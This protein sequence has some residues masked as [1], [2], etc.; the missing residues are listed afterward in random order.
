MNK[1]LNN[2]FIQ[3]GII[4]TLSTVI[5]NVFNYIFH[6]LAA[7]TLGPADYGEIVALFSYMA[8]LSIPFST[9][10][11]LIIRRLGYA[12]IQRDKVAKAIDL[13]FSLRIRH[14]WLI[15]LFFFSIMFVIPRI[16]GLQ[17]STGVVLLFSVYFGLINSFYIAILTGLHFFKQVGISSMLT[18][19]F[20]LVGVLAVFVGFGKLPTIYSWLGGSII[21]SILYAKSILHKIPKI[22]DKDAYVIDQRILKIIFSPATL[23]TSISLLGI[24]LLGNL[25][26]III[27]KIFLDSQVGMYG[28]WSL[29]AKTLFYILGPINALTLVVFSSEDKIRNQESAM[30]VIIGILTIT[31]ICAYIGFSYFG[32]YLVD[33]IFG[34]SFKTIVALLPK[35]ALF[36]TFFSMSN[37]LNN[38]FI[39]RRHKAQVIGFIAAPIYV[40][41]LLQF[42]T[43]IEAVIDVNIIYSSLLS[44]FYLLIYMYQSR[45]TL[46]SF[47]ITR[48]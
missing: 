2:V 43:S 9:I 1:L 33:I 36:G 16:T 30:G 34:N 6:V 11:T 28:A 23:L 46:R 44:A 3:G 47:F 12:G 10:P 17:F 31:G 7:R 19:F 41:L 21:L 27:K 5:V 45:V 22:E 8:V 25:D 38:Y 20:K 15:T 14:W 39:A 35:A 18:S 32:I 40:M 37:I 48:I 4:L 24:T 13:W 42:G 26:I 29:F